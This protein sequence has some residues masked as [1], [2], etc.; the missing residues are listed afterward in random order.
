MVLQ[1]SAPVQNPYKDRHWHAVPRVSLCFSAG[2]V[3]GPR[4]PGH[5][6]HILHI[7]YILICLSTSAWLDQCQSAI[8]YERREQAQVL[9]KIPVS[10]ILGRLPLVPVGAT[11]T[12]PFAM[13]REAADFPGAFCDKLA[14]SGDGCRW[15]YVNSW[16]LRWGTNQ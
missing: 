9:Y 11:G 8:V 7:L 5:I 15:W 6:L 1:T 10:S 2:R 3:Q 14:N 16:A 13:R 4:K 12:I